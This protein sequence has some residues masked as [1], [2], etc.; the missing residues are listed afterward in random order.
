MAKCKSGANR[1]KLFV[2]HGGRC[3]WCGRATRLYPGSLKGR[4]QPRDMATRDHLEPRTSIRRGDYEGVRSVL[5]CFACN[6]SRGD[7]NA[8]AWAR[9][10]A[11]EGVPA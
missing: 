5:A 4:R 1:H 8:D 9:K 6:Q 10:I 2:A 7:M 11:T 3:F